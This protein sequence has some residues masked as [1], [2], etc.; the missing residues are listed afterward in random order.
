[1]GAERD[2]RGFDAPAEPAALG[3]PP[4]LP[5]LGSVAAAH[6][7][8][9]PSTPSASARPATRSKSAVVLGASARASGPSAFAKSGC[10][11]AA[12]QISARVGFASFAFPGSPFVF[13]R[14][15][16]AS[17]SPARTAL[18]ASSYSAGTYGARSACIFR[19]ED[20]GA[21]SASVST[22]R[23]AVSPTGTFAASATALIASKPVTSAPAPVKTGALETERE[24]D[25]GCGRGTDAER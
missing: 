24:T 21:A 8:G 19:S 10:S 12:R 14:T 1:M 13:S 18:S 23:S 2:E 5:T 16:S 3:P 4:A 20:A 15:R 9:F 6:S 25:D 11:V 17:A 7:T 22:A